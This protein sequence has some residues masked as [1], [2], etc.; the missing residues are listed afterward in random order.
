MSRTLDEVLADHREEAAVLRKHVVYGLFDPRE[1]HWLR[2]I[3]MTS[4]LATRVHEHTRKATTGRWPRDAWLLALAADGVRVKARVLEHCD[5]DEDARRREW[6]W[7][8]ALRPQGHCQ[9]NAPTQAPRSM[10]DLISARLTPDM[11]TEQRFGI[12]VA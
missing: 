2:Y 1:P 4:D 12:F 3:G 11:S 5:T 6:A 8:S 10:Y 9:Y 7:I